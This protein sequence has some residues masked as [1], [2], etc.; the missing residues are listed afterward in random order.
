MFTLG[1]NYS[2][3]CEFGVLFSNI[4]TLL[5]HPSNTILP[6][7]ILQVPRRPYNWIEESDLNFEM[8][9]VSNIT[10]LHS[11]IIVNQSPRS[12][13]FIPFSFLLFVK[14]WVL[15]PYQLAFLTHQ[16][17]SGWILNWQCVLFR[18]FCFVPIITFWNTCTVSLQHK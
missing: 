3:W 2:I 10:T 7:L 12:C 9:D 8:L 15:V 6:P 4:Y 11:I 16:D 17:G 18:F 13:N 5:I 1:V 14:S